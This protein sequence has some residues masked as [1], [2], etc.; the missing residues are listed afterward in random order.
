VLSPAQPFSG[1]VVAR[2]KESNA[3]VQ[4]LQAQAQRRDTNWNY[5]GVIEDP[6]MLLVVKLRSAGMAQQEWLT[7]SKGL[8]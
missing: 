3:D 4:K 8:L 2:S 7:I 1:R 5:E 6:A